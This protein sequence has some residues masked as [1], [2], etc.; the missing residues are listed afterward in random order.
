MRRHID[1]ELDARRLAG[2]VP[3]YS[4]GFSLR[5]PSALLCGAGEY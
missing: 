5:A 3:T 4:P 1:A 2:A